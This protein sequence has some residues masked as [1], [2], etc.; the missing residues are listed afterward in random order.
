[1]PEPFVDKSFRKLFLENVNTSI[2]SR[3]PVSKNRPCWE[4][5]GWNRINQAVYSTREFLIK[6]DNLIDAKYKSGLNINFQ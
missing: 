1:M 2:K 6:L 4:A 5:I 3:L